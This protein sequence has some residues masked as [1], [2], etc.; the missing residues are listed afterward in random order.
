MVR[1]ILL[2]SIALLASSFPAHAEWYEA[3]SKHFVVY[4]DDT[5]DAAKKITTQLEQFD[6]A[7][8]L[9][10]RVP[11]SKRGPAARI[12]IFVVDDRDEVQKLYGS[13]G[14][15]VAGFM[16]PRASGSVGFVPKRSEGD[17]DARTVLHHEYAHFFMFNDWPTAVFPP[18]FTEGFAEFHATARYDKEGAILFGAVPAY[19]KY[20]V[21]EMNLLPLRQLLRIDPGKLD[22]YQRDALYSR[23]WLMLHYLSFDPA[24]RKQLADYIVAITAGKPVEE[25]TKVFGNLDQLDITLTSHAKLRSLPSFRF[26]PAEL[27]I[28]DVALRKLTPG[29]AATIYARMAS[30]RGVNEKTAPR[31]AELARKAATAF[32]NDAG[33]Q[34]VLAEA[35]FDVKNYAGAEAAADRALAADPKSVHAHLYKGMTR[36]AIAEKAKATDPAVWRDIRKWYAAANRLDPEDPQPLIQFYNSF[37]AAK[38]PA[39][40][41]AEDGLLYAYALAPYDKALRMQAARIHLIRNNAVEARNAMLPV[42][43]NFD[44]KRTETLREILTALDTSGAAAALKVMDDQRAKADAER[45]KA[46]AGKTS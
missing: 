9:L 4:T 14:A 24:R 2:A 33:A 3:S 1:K 6:K 36:Q 45:D 12:S 26:T 25:A 32:P 15:S 16:D 43:F 11:D 31:V 18:W 34:N 13:S 20:T 21:G 29:E 19:R 46:K 39:P 8:R 27:V 5:P 40:K 38:Q 41:M 44:S 37:D 10:R 17:L 7:M 23:G 35:E 28:G 30:V 42:V 22:N